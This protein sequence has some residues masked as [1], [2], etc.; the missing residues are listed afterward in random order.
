M[1]WMGLMIDFQA[2]LI[3][4]IKVRFKELRKVILN[5]NLRD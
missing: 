2:I 4:R 5:V 3:S 1:V